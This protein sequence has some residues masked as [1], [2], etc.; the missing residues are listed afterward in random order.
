MIPTV[1]S[2]E[3]VQLGARLMLQL[4]PHLVALLHHLCVKVLG[5]C[6]SDYPALPVG[7]PS[8]VWQEELEVEDGRDD[9]SCYPVPLPSS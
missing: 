8:G 5:V 6:P 3:P 7:A 4:G 1:P 9:Q 2:P